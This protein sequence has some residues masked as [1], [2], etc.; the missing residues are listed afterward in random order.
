MTFWNRLITQLTAPS[1]LLRSQNELNKRLNMMQKN[2]QLQ[3]DASER[4]YQELK[5]QTEQLESEFKPL[6][7]QIENDKKNEQQWRCGD[8]VAT[9]ITLTLLTIWGIIAVWSTAT[10][11]DIGIDI[12]AVNK[13]T[14]YATLCGALVAM[15]TSRLPKFAA[16][17]TCAGALTGL[18]SVTLPDTHEYWDGQEII[19]CSRDISKLPDKQL[20][21]KLKSLKEQTRPDTQILLCTPQDATS[22]KGPEDADD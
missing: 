4:Q 14:A 6:Q 19:V 10:K 18:M 8:N 3:Y 1:R 12:D 17:L 2:L 16:V 9:G 5:K 20:E 21:Q 11:T 22:F 15:I 7:Q 13:W